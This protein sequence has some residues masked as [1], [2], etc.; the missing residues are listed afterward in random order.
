MVDD[1]GVWGSVGLVWSEQCLNKFVV[2]DHSHAVWVKLIH[3][4]L[5]AEGKKEV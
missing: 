4:E 2:E 3:Q 5:N 1:E